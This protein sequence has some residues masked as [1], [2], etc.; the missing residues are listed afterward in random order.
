[1]SEY[2]SEKKIALCPEG[3]IWRK[4]L[5]EDCYELRKILPVPLTGQYTLCLP[6]I[7]TFVEYA[8]RVFACKVCFVCTHKPRGSVLTSTSADRDN[9]LFINFSFLGVTV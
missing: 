9:R 4:K 1:M 8:L 3:I 7:H 6:P 2:Y 5:V